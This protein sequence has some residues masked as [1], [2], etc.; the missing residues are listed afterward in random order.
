MTARTTATIGIVAI[1]AALALVPVAWHCSGAV[2]GWNFVIYAL[3]A[4]G[5]SIIGS[6]A[7]RVRKSRL[8]GIATTVLVVAAALF[9]VNGL[10]VLVCD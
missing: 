9:V 3:L 1:L 7:G 6:A 2:E 10:A 4:A 5:G 8:V